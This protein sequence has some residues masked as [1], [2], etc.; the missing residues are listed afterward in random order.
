[1]VT[2][3]KTAKKTATSG[4][5]K[6]ASSTKAKA[7]TKTAPVSKDAEPSANGVDA[8]LVDNLM[9]A[10]RERI[11]SGE[12]S[13]GSWLRQEKLAQELG[14]SRM[15][16]REALRQLQAL[17]IVEIIANRGARVRLPSALEVIEVYEMRGV[18]ESHAAAAAARLI[19]SE[20]LDRLQETVDSFK[21]IVRDVESKDPERTST[22]RWRWY[23]ANTTFHSVI[24]EAAGNG[25]MIEMLDGLR[26]KIPSTL[27]WVGLGISDVRRLQRNLAEHEEIL[28][29]IS[30]G[31]SS[32][33]REL[34]LEHNQHASDLLVRA[35]EDLVSG[36]R[37]ST[38]R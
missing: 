28:E 15:P 4:A 12:I 19:T 16:I 25:T 26:N 18:L 6:S 21:E 22:A 27:T 7:K 38:D 37:G 30:S 31:D 20:Q 14:V 8:R 33:A 36:D 23:E 17:G 11:D 3:R 9:E 5:A 35:R 2:P 13:V 34:F 24:L 1:M 29:A 32:R 10:I